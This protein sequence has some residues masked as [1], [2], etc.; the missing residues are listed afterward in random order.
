VLRLAP[1][2]VLIVPVSEELFF[3]LYV[4]RFIARH[5]GFPAGL[6]TSSL[7][8]AL[9]HFKSSGLLIYLGIGCILAWVYQRTGRIVA[10]IVGHMT[11]NAIVLIASQIAPG[12]DV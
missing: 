2:I 7:L 1:W 11:L 6:I 4:F 8:F 12:L 3:R 5:V 10:P 9:I